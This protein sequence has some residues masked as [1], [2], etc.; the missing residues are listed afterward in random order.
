MGGYSSPSVL[1][2]AGA[3]SVT[4]VNQGRNPNAHLHAASGSFYVGLQKG[5]VCVSFFGDGPGLFG[6][7]AAL[8]MASCRSQFAPNPNV[9]CLSLLTPSFTLLRWQAAPA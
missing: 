1:P 2:P 8:W 3:A 5:T 9:K 4:M 7:K 6:Q